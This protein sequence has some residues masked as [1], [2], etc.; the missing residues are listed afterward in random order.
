MDTTTTTM[1]TTTTITMGTMATMVTAM[2]MT[3]TRLLLRRL[4]GTTTTR[5]HRPTPRG[6]RQALPLAST[7]G[8][9]IGR[10]P[11]SLYKET[12]L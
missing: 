7:S 12:T 9:R 11:Q 1:G 10:D 5:Y 2:G 4:T 8:L 3:T 6:Q